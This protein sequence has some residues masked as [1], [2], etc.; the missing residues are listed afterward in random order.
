MGKKYLFPFEKEKKNIPWREISIGFI[1]FYTFVIILGLAILKTS[2]EEN[3]NTMNSFFQT[4][5][6]LIVVPTGDL[7]RIPKAVELAKKFSTSNIFITGV[8]KKNSVDM[9]IP[10]SDF[11]QIDLNLM[12]IDYWARNTIENVIST[13]KFIGT[14][15][16]T[17]KI[18]IVS[19]DYHIFRLKMI[20]EHFT[21][22]NQQN[23]QF[24]YYGVENSYRD[25]DNLIKLHKE[26]FKL[27]RG[28]LIMKLWT[29]EISI[30]S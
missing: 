11:D 20:F 5:P 16:N 6:D 4:S 19:S 18:L 25:V 1:G 23:Y 3:A 13:L 27:I 10:K 26:I 15:N 28:W 21:E 2:S 24:Y 22:D 12:E 9:I 17:Q 14:L 29:P 8:Y 30:D 7:G